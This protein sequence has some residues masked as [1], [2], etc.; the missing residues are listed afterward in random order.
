MK[1]DIEIAQEARM[2]PIAEIAASL[3]LADED[4]IPY[5]R[6]KAKINH[7]LIHRPASRASWS[8]SRPSAP[9]RRARA[10]PPPAW[11]WPTP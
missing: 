2:K 3:G 8:W 4:V 5:G 1:S 11:A 10:R 7:R 6:Y 9:P